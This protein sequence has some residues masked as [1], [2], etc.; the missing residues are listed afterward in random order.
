MEAVADLITTPAMSRMVP[1]A[2]WMECADLRTINAA[3]A[4]EYILPIAKRYR[5]FLTRT[6]EPRSQSRF[7]KC[8][9]GTALVYHSDYGHF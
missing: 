4:G 8:D 5:A 7:G 6:D 9:N 3:S 1:A 2:A